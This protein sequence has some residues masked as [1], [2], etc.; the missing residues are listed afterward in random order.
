MRL[1]LRRATI[2]LA[3]VTAV[4][5]LS[6]APAQAENAYH[7]SA[8]D[9]ADCPALPA[10]AQASTWKCYVMT[11]VDGYVRLDK[12]SANIS[13]PWRLT[14]AQG[15]VNGVTVAKY[16]AFQADAVP[17]VSGI[18]GTPFVTPHPTGWQLK[19]DGTGLVKP[20]FTIPDKLGLKATII[21]DGLA[22]TCSIGSDASPVMVGP[23]VSWVIPWMY[24]GVLMNKTQIYD[25]VYELP[26]AKGCGDASA[27][28][29]VNT[30]IGLPANATSNYLKV[31]W[32]QREKKY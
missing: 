25:E 26:A 21:G 27:N 13:K 24:D 3:A 8:A 16:G 29:T 7:P 12:M 2:G 17:F 20:G 1:A 23:R 9:F 6:A 11:A 10:G 31:V 4:M 22:S 32:A 30:L 14:V 18:P 28:L 5:G 19:V 15:K